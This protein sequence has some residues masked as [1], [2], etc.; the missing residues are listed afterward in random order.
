MMVEY[1]EAVLGGRAGSPSTVSWEA[2]RWPPCRRCTSPLP[3]WPPTSSPS[4]ARSQGAVG[5][6]YAARSGFAL[7]Y[8]GEHYVVDL[9]AGLGAHRGRPARSRR[10]VGARRALRAGR[11]RRRAATAR[12]AAQRMSATR[13]AAATED[14]RGADEDASATDDEEMPRVRAHAARSAALRRSSSLSAIAFL[15]FVLPQLAGLQDTWHR[16]D[17]GRPVV[18]GDR[19]RR[20]EVL[21]FG[22]YMLLFRTVFVRGGDRDRLARR[23]TR[24]RW[25]ALAATRL[26]AAAR[27]RRRRADGVGAAPRRAWRARLVAVPDGRLPRPALRASTWLALVDLRPRAARRASS[28]AG[29]VRGHGRAGDLRRRRDRRSRWR[30]RFVPGRPR[31]APR[32]LGG[33]RTGAS[34]AGSR[35]R[36]PRCRPR[37]PAGVRTAI[38]LDRASATAACSARSSGGASTS[39]RCGRRFHAFG[40]GAAVRR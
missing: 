24:S 4:R 14:R 18:A 13:R 2:T 32:A 19:A 34:R 25:P 12:R 6:A 36:W 21:S 5:W 23:A 9:L 17:A 29:A 16:I 33:R 39:R 37:C 11:A 7:V 10:R 28:R 3:S 22:G 8:L 35:E 27:R 15:Y 20:F 40:D 26:F 31:A 30:W 1:G 38:E